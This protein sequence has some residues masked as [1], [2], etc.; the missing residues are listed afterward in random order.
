MTCKQPLSFG[1]A[2]NLART[3]EFGSK[4]MRV[5]TLQKRVLEYLK[6]NKVDVL[7]WLVL[8]PDV[9]II[10]NVWY[11]VEEVVHIGK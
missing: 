6:L 5:S 7:T 9:N 10:E 1:I 11:L 4:T 3:N 2:D 8:K